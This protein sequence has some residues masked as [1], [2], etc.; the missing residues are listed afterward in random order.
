[1]LEVGVRQA[2]HGG[3]GVFQS[4]HHRLAKSFDVPIIKVNFHRRSRLG[5]QI[6]NLVNVEF[7]RSFVIQ[8]LELLPFLISSEKVYRIEPK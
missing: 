5:S 6:P 3:R 7:I 2:P 4:L 8:T 1:M